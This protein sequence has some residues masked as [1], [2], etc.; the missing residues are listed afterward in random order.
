MFKNAKYPVT[1]HVSLRTPSPINPEICYHFYNPVTYSYLLPH[2]NRVLLEKLIRSRL[3]KKFLEFY[4]T[5]RFT[6]S[7]TNARHL[8]LSLATVN[9]LTSHFLKIYLNIILPSM[10][11]SS[12]RSVS[13]R[14]PHQTPVHISILLHTCYVPRP[15]H[16]SRFDHPKNIR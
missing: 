5:Q 13:L 9:V 3:V 12:K 8:S 7:F 1:L 16:S 14:F 10:P 15:I 6:T 4:G 11:A 2:W